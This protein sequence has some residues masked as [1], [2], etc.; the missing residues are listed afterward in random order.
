[1]SDSIDRVFVKAISTIKAL[2]ARKGPGSLPQPPVDRRIRLYGLYKQA[3]GMMSTGFVF[4]LPQIFCGLDQESQK[5]MLTRGL[6]GDVD[7]I[8]NRPSGKTPEDLASRRKW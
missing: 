5:H 4:G 7:G 6:E 8:M 3:T 1:M 2:S